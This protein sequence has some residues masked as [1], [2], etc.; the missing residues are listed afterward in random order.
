MFKFLRLVI[1]PLNPIDLDFK[2]MPREPYSFFER[3]KIYFKGKNTGDKYTNYYFLNIFKHG[4]IHLLLVLYFPIIIICR[5]CNF[6]FVIINYWQFG[7]TAQ[8]LSFLIR[9]N[10]LNNN[11]NKI[12]VYA[13]EKFVSNKALL[14]IF[15]SRIKIISNIILCIITYPLFHSRLLRL[16][17]LKYDEHSH[18]SRTYIINKNHKHFNRNFFDF[19]DE[20]RLNLRKIFFEE[21]NFKPDSK[22]ACMNLRTLKFYNDK[23]YTVRNT[24]IEKYLDTYEYLIS[25]GYK[26]ICLNEDKINFKN[27]ENIFFYSTLNKNFR[28]DLQIYILKQANIFIT[29]NFGPKNVAS[30]LCTPSLICDAFPYTSIIPY[31]ETDIT[32]PKIIEKNNKKLSFN[33]IFDLGYFHSIVNE[34]NIN[35]IENSSQDILDGISLILDKTY[36]E[37]HKTNNIKLKKIMSKKISCINGQGNISEKFLDKNKFLIN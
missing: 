5:L 27:F 22:Y 3:I 36:G 35:I 6:K 29:N 19:I 31:N 11:K 32:I 14:K 2:R 21:F 16:S 28:S 4:F 13:P 10:I 17:I 1:K 7:T 24:T 9:D 20:E 37:K 15:S 30:A 18:N 23:R 33:E 12:F 34:K 8:H 25:N 26:V